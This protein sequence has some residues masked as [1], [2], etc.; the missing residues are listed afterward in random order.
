MADDIPHQVQGPPE[1]LRSSSGPKQSPLLDLPVEIWTDIIDRATSAWTPRDQD[2]DLES[3]MTYLDRR[4]SV[5]RGEGLFEMVYAYHDL[6]TLGAKSKR[7]GISAEVERSMT[8]TLPRLDAEQKKWSRIYAGFVGFFTPDTYSMSLNWAIWTLEIAMSC[9][10]PITDHDN[11]RASR[12]SCPC[13][14]RWFGSAFQILQHLEHC[15]CPAW[16][17][18]AD[19]WKLA[20]SRMPAYNL[21]LHLAHPDRKLIP[22]NFHQWIRHV[23]TPGG[24]HVNPYLINYLVEWVF[25]TLLEQ[26]RAR[27]GDL[28]TMGQIRRGRYYPK[29]LCK[30]W[31]ETCGTSML[32]GQDM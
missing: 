25:G 15:Q 23:T 2:E 26:T 7:P 16:P 32:S 24:K 18:H 14:Y 30:F 29:A 19:I 27:H 12:Q 6:A 28:I 10:F 22:Q 17:D 11:Q 9:Y 20:Q 1:P 13:C 31:A 3:Y 8:R 5:P 4:L 21:P